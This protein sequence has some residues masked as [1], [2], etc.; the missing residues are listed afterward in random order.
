MEDLYGF[1]FGVNHF[2]AILIDIPVNYV[3]QQTH[4]NSSVLWPIDMH[5]I[6]I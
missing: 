2:Y 3:P 4:A 1:H 5:I 6:E